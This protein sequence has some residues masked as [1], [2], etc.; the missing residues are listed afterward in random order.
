ME[1]DHKIVCSS[2]VCVCVCGG[3]GGGTPYGLPSSLIKV[4]HFHVGV[5]GRYGYRIGF[6]RISHRL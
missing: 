4:N 3:G 6:S 5:D 2:G 1:D